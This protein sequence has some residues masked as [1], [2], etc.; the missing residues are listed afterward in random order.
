MDLD[1]VMAALEAAGTPAVR[2]V[3]AA[4]GVR[5]FGVDGMALHALA[6]QLGTQPRLAGELWGTGQHDA[7]MLAALVVDPGSVEVER[8]LTWAEECDNSLEANAISVVAAR[9]PHA[10]QLSDQLRGSELEL[11]ALVGWNLVS[12][13][14]RSGRVEDEWFIP[15]LDELE[16]HLHQ[17]PSPVRHGMNI[18]LCSIGLSRGGELREQALHVAAA[19][20]EV[21]VDEGTTPDAT[22]TIQRVVVRDAM[23][24]SL[25]KR[26]ERR[27]RKKRRR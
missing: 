9:S 20:G 1:A 19:L 12:V 10:R 14:A 24:E 16:H 2:E 23:D 22:A 26:V 18:A 17:R 5:G 15:L 7:R 6:D 11:A 3:Q 21:V 13:L 4:Q 27:N 25:R 8:L